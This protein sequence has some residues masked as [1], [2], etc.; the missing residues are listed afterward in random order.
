MFRRNVYFT[1][2]DIFTLNKNIKSS[3]CC[4]SKVFTQVLIHLA[5]LTIF[6]PDS[7]DDSKDRQNCTQSGESSNDDV[8]P[9]R[10]GITCRLPYGNTTAPRCRERCW[11]ITIDSHFSPRFLKELMVNVTSWQFTDFAVSR[12]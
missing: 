2:R 6:T 10:A 4:C 12:N 5:S 9:R 8:L 7:Q 3:T 1:R 11:K